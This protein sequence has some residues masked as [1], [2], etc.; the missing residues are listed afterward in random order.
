MKFK[1]DNLL[2]Y[3]EKEWLSEYHLSS[4]DNEGK[5]KFNHF[6]LKI[7]EDLRVT[8]STFQRY[9]TKGPIKVDTIVMRSVDGIIK[10]LKYSESSS[11][12]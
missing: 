1:Q 2:R 9:K 10:M 6:E 5:V 3:P 12:V 11:D 8:W 7:E 4:I